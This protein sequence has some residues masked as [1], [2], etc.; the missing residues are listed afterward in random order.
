[1]LFCLYED[2]LVD[3]T[4]FARLPRKRPEAG[5]DVVSLLVFA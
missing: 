2:L 1:M 5:A 3:G 4:P